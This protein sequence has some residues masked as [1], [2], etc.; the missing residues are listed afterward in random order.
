MSDK[1][2][3]DGINEEIVVF[4]SPVYETDFWKVFV[5]DLVFTGIVVYI[6]DVVDNPKTLFKGRS[7]INSN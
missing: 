1:A 3:G 2:A 7:N 4:E 6:R 5:C